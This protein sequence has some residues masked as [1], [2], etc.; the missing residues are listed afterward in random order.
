MIGCMLEGAIG[1][2]A[3]VHFAIAKQHVISRIDLDGPSLGAFNPIDSNVNFND[4][5]ISVID[6]PGL[7]IK[8]IPHVNWFN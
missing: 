7:G 4:A 8:Q 5:V 6:T 2:T 3:A 1:A